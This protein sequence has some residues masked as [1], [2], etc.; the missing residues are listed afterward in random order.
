[1]SDVKSKGLYSTLAGDPMLGQL[2]NLFVAEMPSRT[3]KLIDRLGACDWEGLR[4]AVNHSKGRGRQLRLPRHSRPRPPS[5]KTRFAANC[6]RR[7]S[8]RPPAS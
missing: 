4:Q 6:R 1:M 5:W 7:R 8:A 3:T 2:V